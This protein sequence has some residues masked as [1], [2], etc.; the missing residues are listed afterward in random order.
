MFRRSGA[1]DRMIRWRSTRAFVVQIVFRHRLRI[2]IS[3]L[4]VFPMRCC[5]RR[6]DAQGLQEGR[7]VSVERNSIPDFCRTCEEC[8]SAST[9]LV[10]WLQFNVN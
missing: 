10:Q 1:S 6:T 9:R 3:Q 8:S 7:K 2:L 5:R 4:R